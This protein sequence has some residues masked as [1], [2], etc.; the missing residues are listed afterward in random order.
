M[1][2]SNHRILA[3]CCAA[4]L[5]LGLAG[6]FVALRTQPAR[7]AVLTVTNANDAGAGSLRQA[8]ID[9]NAT[10]GFDIITFNIPAAPYTI[11][12][13]SPMPAITDAVDIRGNDQPGYAGA[14]VIEL[15]GAGAGAGADGLVCNGA[16][17]GVDGLAINR[18]NGN[19]I[20]LNGALF[21]S[22]S[23]CYIGTD[24]TG[25]IDLGNGL[26]GI[27]LSGSLSTAIGGTM[28]AWDKNLISGNDG[29]GVL[30]NGSSNTTIQ[31]NYIGTDT[32][33]TVLLSNNTN[34]IQVQNG[35][36]NTVVGGSVA[37]AGNLISEN[38]ANGVNVDNCSGCLI[39]GNRIGTNAAGTAALPN[40][41]SGV[42]LR[43]GAT[44][45]TVGGTNVFAINLLSG[46]G[47]N[48][49]TL[50]NADGNT[51]IGNY[52][53]TN[54]TGTTALP[55]GGTGVLLQAGSGSNTIG[56]S[57]VMERNL[58]SGNP[59]GLQIDDSDSNTVL[60]NRIGTDAAGTTAIPN[61]YGISLTAG[62]TGNTIGGTAAGAGNIV[63]GNNGTGVYLNACNGNY[64]YG[65]MVGTDP[66]GTADL[67]NSSTGIHLDGGSSSNTIGGATTGHRNVVCGNG[68]AGVFLYNASNN[69]VQGNYVGTSST[70]SA[71]IMN[72]DNGVTLGASSNGNT[73]G[74]TNPGEGNLI[75]G[76]RYSGVYIDNSSGN[77]LWGNRIGTNA[78][79]TL[80]LGNGI[81]GVSIFWS[82]NNNV[83]G[84]TAGH[85]NVISGND[86]CGVFLYGAT[87]NHVTGNYI[88]ID[89]NG[90]AAVANS[91]DGVGIRSSANGNFIGGAAPGDGNVISGNARNG[92]YV[93]AS[94]GN[95]ILG[96][97]IGTDVSG[98]PSAQANGSYGVSLVA[99]ANNTVVGSAAGGNVI[100]AN[101]QG[102]VNI[103]AS[104][105]ALVRGNRIGTDLGGT[106]AMG[107]G[108]NGVQLQGG[109][110]NNTV[111]GSG[112]GEGN[113][114]SANFWHGIYVNGSTGN[115]FYGNRVGT[116]LAGATALQNR[117]YGVYLRFSADNNEIGGTAPGSGNLIS[118]N[119]WGGVDIESSTSNSIRGN[120]IGTDAAGTAALAN[121]P[122]GIML[123]G[124]TNNTIGGITAAERNLV[125]GNTGEGIALLFASNANTVIGNYAGTDVTGTADLGNG[126]NGVLVD[127]GSAA[128][129]IGV[130]D[131]GNLCSG[132]GLDGVRITGASDNN[133][134]RGNLL[135]TDATGTAILSNDHSGA[136]IDG[137]NGNMVGGTTAA[138]RNLMSGN[139]MCGICIAN[140]TTGN[141]VTGNYIGTD[142]TGSFPMAN[143]LD[144]VLL[145][146]A[147]NNN[148]VGSGGAGEGNLISGNAG[149]GVL[150]ES[151]TGN[152]IAYNIIGTDSSESAPLPNQA[153]GMSLSS[154]SNNSV[155]Y[156]NHIYDNH[157]DGIQISGTSSCVMGFNVIENNEGDGISLTGSS[158]NNLI[159]NQITGNGGI[160]VVVW[161]PASICDLISENSIY[162][163]GGLAI[164][165][166]GDGVT[167]ND[168]N[169]DNPARPNRGYNFPVF[170]QAEFPLE[171]GTVQVSGTAP[172]D[173]RVEIAYVGAVPDPSGHGQAYAPRTWVTADATGAF[174]ASLTGLNIGDRISAIAISPATHP[175]GQGNTS[176]YSAN[177]AVVSAEKTLGETTWYVAE[178]STAE[179]FDTWLLL[180]NPGER[181]ADV[182]VTFVSET[183]AAPP[184]PVKVP[185]GSRVSLRELDYLADEWSVSAIV[186]SN[187][188]IVVERSTYW[189]RTRFGKQGE[190][191]APA[192]YEMGAGHANL[193]TPAGA[194]V[195]AAGAGQSYYFAEGATAGGFET[196]VLLLNPYDADAHAKVTLMTGAGA[197]VEKDVTV[198][199]LTRRTVSL[200]ELLPD[201]YDVATRVTSDRP[202]VADRS[203][204][205]DPDAADLNAWEM[206][207]GSSTTASPAPATG[208]FLAEGSTG[209]GFDTWVLLQNPNATA[210][211]VDVDFYNASGPAGH[212]D[213]SMPAQSRATVRVSDYVPDD[214]SVSTG[215]SSDLPVVVERSMY[216][217]ALETAVPCEMR[218]GHA[219]SGSIRAGNAWMVPEGSS[220]GGFDTF[221]L[222]A[223]TEDRTASL[224]VTFMTGGGPVGPFDF[225]VPA[226]SRCTIRVSDWLPDQ[227]E[228][229]TLVESDTQVVVERSMYWDRR[230]ASPD[231]EELQPYEMM[232]GH[233]ASGLDP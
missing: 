226:G 170:D 232:G 43:N 101:S 119:G 84:A 162:G 13:A 147:A 219:N 80:D 81:E 107:N 28:S 18:F 149:N 7:A 57:A 54:A 205:W 109:A 102:G 153:N 11:T 39:Q 118:G 169:N 156:S 152:H 228:V 121:T 42:A 176:E 178:G 97:F 137:G 194:T 125:S 86:D 139:T 203:M 197:V 191:G 154:G 155:V 88:G 136:F 66:A 59:G 38:G 180:Q 10:P 179:G 175:S 23:G 100:S 217:N 127:G 173:A 65:N 111:G 62:S 44:G 61:G 27:L 16:G 218:E 187:E 131:H 35:S 188:P 168:G 211:G 110:S 122:Y 103:N 184:V 25:T 181:D 133:T 114:I 60:G 19:G 150:V 74:G 2:K 99:G 72:G 159:E 199:A 227:M 71:V 123:N 134:V 182:G 105:G 90:I 223:N 142:A 151:S 198:P 220:G 177:A 22:I 82:A 83:G 124:S 94:T 126:G 89:A 4:V 5:V 106:A 195:T 161:D 141:T 49:I 143:G 31:G 163:N 164:D 78:A 64:F 128:N 172:P 148:T 186:D 17:L 166:L 3:T 138:E 183:G 185:A 112:A 212:V 130:A 209:G 190:E 222:I 221:V 145:R 215:V 96:N 73:I 92:V 117:R 116:D 132:N 47:G 214:F 231:G 157:T 225:N 229:S 15:N 48:G 233:C 216:W 21:S 85:R 144:G 68:S 174:S 140:T 230:A 77:N 41:F 50:D 193:A 30:I 63:S 201:S 33:G 24:T 113:L 171:G 95:V 55:N 146:T 8:I 9:A 29:H 36:N 120:R 207:G 69:I 189:N 58:I 192:P 196:W 56:G 46:N 37:G 6:A 70:G 200:D 79:G 206:R 202:L 91:V 76:N 158:N 98:G 1:Y 52:I 224:R 208:W 213:L 45:N 167:P 67:G 129:S 104:T 32:T 160:G 14:P 34:G 26:N 53:G 135:G 165:L 108:F 93:D 87:G 204:Y 51:V 115:F 40:T 12:L 75:S 20:V 210:A